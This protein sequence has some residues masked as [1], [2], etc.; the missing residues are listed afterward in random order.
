MVIDT[1]GQGAIGCTPYDPTVFDNAFVS[2]SKDSS[3]SA[4]KE[5]MD[6]FTFK[7]A[8]IGGIISGA[9]TD[10][11]SA[12]DAPTEYFTIDGQRIS[13]PSHGIYIVRKGN[14]VSK[15]IL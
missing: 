7:H 5:D 1:Y 11:T 9:V 12:N 10:I 3:T 15:V 4:E 6:V 8:R 14:T 2:Y 13:H